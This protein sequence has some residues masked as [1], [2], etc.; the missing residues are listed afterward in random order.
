MKQLA[1]FCFPLSP[2][3]GKCPP[4]PLSR[5]MLSATPTVECVGE[6]L[7]P[8]NISLE[9]FYASRASWSDPCLS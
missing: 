7:K 6:M 1:L 8:F 4:T 2:A 3:S 5:R 9:T